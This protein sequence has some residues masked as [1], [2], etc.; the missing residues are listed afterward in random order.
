MYVL[1]MLVCPWLSS[2]IVK[3]DLFNLFYLIFLKFVVKIRL[4]FLIL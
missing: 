3:L 1:S 2:L 4:I